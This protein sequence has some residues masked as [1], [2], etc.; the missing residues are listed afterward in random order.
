MKIFRYN[1]KI[2]ELDELGGLILDSNL[3]QFVVHKATL[4]ECNYNIGLFIGPW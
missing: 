3:E 4:A 2:S 1:R